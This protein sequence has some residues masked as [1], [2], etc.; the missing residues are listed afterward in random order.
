MLY[1]KTILNQDKEKEFAFQFGPSFD[2]FHSDCEPRDGDER[3]IPLTLE[4]QSSSAELLSFNGKKVETTVI[5]NPNKRELRVRAQFRSFLYNELNA[6][7]GDILVFKR[8]ETTDSVRHDF[9]PNIQ[10][11]LI[12]QTSPSFDIYKKLLIDSASVAISSSYTCVV[13]DNTIEDKVKS[14]DDINSFNVIYYGAPGSGKSYLVKEFLKQHSNKTFI[15]TFHPEYDYNNFVGAYKPISDV[16]GII[17][18]K[19]VPQ[20]FIKAYIY[21]WQHRDENVFLDIE[22]INRGNC[23]LIFGSIFQLLDRKDDGYSSYSID[24][25]EDAAQYIKSQLQSYPE[26]KSVICQRTDTTEDSFEYSKIMLPSNLYI[27]ATMNTSDQSL[28]PMDS[29]FKR[30]WDWIYVPIQYDKIQDVKISINSD[31]YSWADFLRVINKKILKI[32]QSEDKQLGTYFVKVTNNLISL[33]KFR[34]KVL[35]YL[36]NDI[37]KDEVGSADNIFRTDTEEFSFSDLFESAKSANLI[38]SMLDQLGLQCS[39][40]SNTVI[41]SISN[42]GESSLNPLESDDFIEKTT[43]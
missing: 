9:F 35:F 26:Y 8:K 16:N 18:Y 12:K 11:D 3:E 32:T 7:I 33:E 31:L 39:N 42:L 2:F 30:R 34:D 23:A 29:A 41:D 1:I 4:F 43:N 27:Y 13:S 37:Y 14:A 21:A 17:D 24:I 36:W 28:F 6:N 25:D 20:I 22:E 40:S 38:K 15:T 5:Y 10:F 19:F